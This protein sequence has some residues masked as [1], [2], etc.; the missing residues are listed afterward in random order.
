MTR[1]RAILCLAA[2]L[3]AL[4]ACV[5][6]GPGSHLA[7]PAATPA[8]GDFSGQIDIGGGRSL[9]LRCLGNGSPTVVFESG[10]HDS[11]DPWNLTET[12]P[13]V[14]HAPPVFPGI[15]QVTHVCE[16]DRPGTLRYTE[17]PTLT[18]RST[19]LNAP[20]T[21]PSMASDLHTLLTKAGV[22]GPYLLVGHSF[23]GLIIRLFAQTYPADTVGLVFVDALG[24]DIKPLF[25]A[26]WPTYAAVLNHPGTPLDAQPG[27][28]TVDVDGAI[29]AVQQAPALPR[30]PL[31]VLSKTE[32]FAAAPSVSPLVRTEL[33]H[34]WP[35][36]QNTLVALQPQ[37]PHLLA[38]GSDH[39]VQIHDPDLTISAIQLTLDRARHRQ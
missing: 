18:T 16:Y 5:S 29:Q 17:P 27:F 1:F 37:T 33:E 36:V 28:E 10:I 24:V 31:A 8:H 15:G 23:G 6:T 12:Q 34:A 4:A 32:P 21:L 9:Y 22:P 2:L 26:D 38:T 7:S 14:V 25:G 13:P 19:P 39:Y 11:S 30:V 3:A 35:Q 20:R